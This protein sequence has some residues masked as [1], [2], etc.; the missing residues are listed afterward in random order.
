[1]PPDG[2]MMARN[3]LDHVPFSD[4]PGSL[5]LTWITRPLGRWQPGVS[6]SIDQQT[7]N[8]RLRRSATKPGRNSFV[9]R[10]REG[11]SHTHNPR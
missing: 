7:S 8:E 9:C 6:R 10:S 2:A 3:S 4:G 1:M 11:M 5:E